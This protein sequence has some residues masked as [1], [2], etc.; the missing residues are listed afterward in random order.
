MTSSLPGRC[1]VSVNPVRSAK[2]RACDSRSARLASSDMPSTG[3]QPHVSKPGVARMWAML[4]D[5]AA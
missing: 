3:G 5:H 4:D 1:T 2:S